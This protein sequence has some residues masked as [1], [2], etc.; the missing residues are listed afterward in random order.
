MITGEAIV[1]EARKHLGRPFV[2]QGRG[3]AGLD[4]AGLIIKAASDL[5]IKLQEV[6]GYGRTPKDEEL[7]GQMDKQLI[8][9]PQHEPWR[10]GDVLLMRFGSEPQHVALVSKLDPTYILHTN[11][12][13]GRVVEHILDH[14]WQR[15][16]VRTYRLPGAN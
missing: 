6:H 4:C 12:S 5:G 7:G 8:R 11:S 9:L 14:R 16:V 15:L 1:E 2:H 3:G 10:V 13:I